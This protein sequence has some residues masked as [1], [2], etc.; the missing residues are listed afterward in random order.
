MGQ[1]MKKRGFFSLVS[2]FLSYFV[3][4]FVVQL[5]AMTVILFSNLPEILEITNPADMQ[6]YMTEEIMTLILEQYMHHLTLVT[7]ACALCVM[8]VFAV[9]LRRDKVYEKQMGIPERPAVSFGKYLPIIALGAALSIGF[10]NI[11]L[12]SNIRMYSES[13]QATSTAFYE[14]NFIIQLIGL[15]VLVPVAEELMFRGL[16]YRRMSHM[17]GA[18]MAIPLSAVVFGVYHGNLVQGIYGF[19]MGCVL[20]W[21]Y[22]KYGSTKAPVLLHVTA[23]LVSVIATKADFFTWIFQDFP[24]IAVVTAAC[25]ALGSGIF[26]LIRNMFA[27]PQT[28]AEEL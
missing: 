22:E 3:I 19:V 27:K 20:A 25:A 26:V 23:N 24:R 28:E 11:L 4:S 13:Y 12:L 2:P 10:N 1:N 21:L 14:E 9:M 15:G 5:I 18:R 6:I 17:A 16:I 8:P 7:A